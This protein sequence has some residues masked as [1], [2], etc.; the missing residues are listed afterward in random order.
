MGFNKQNDWVA[1]MMNVE[2]NDNIQLGSN[3]NLTLYSNGITPDNTGLKDR[4]YYKNI[5]QIQ[6]KFV[7]EN[8]QFNDTAF[9]Q[10]Y[11]SATKS[12]QEF[13]EIDFVERMLDEIGVSPYDSS[14]LAKPTRKVQ[15]ISA[16]ITPFHDKNRTTYGTANLWETGSATFSD[17]E[18]AQANFVRDENGNK[19]DWTPNDRSGF[20]SLF[21]PAIAYASYD[22]DVYDE[23]GRLIHRKGELKLDENG[24]PYTE[25]L[26]DRE[27]FGKDV[28]KWSDTFSVEGS[29][30]NK[31]DIF[32]SDGLDKSTWKIVGKTALMIAPYFTPLGAAWGWAN[33]VGG[34]LTAM[35]SLVKSL[36]GLFTGDSDNS[37]LAKSMNK[38]DNIMGR[39]KPTMSDSAKGRFWSLENLGDLVV[40]SSAQL[41]SQR[42]IANALA[43]WAPFKSKA[44]NDLL[45]RSVSTGYMAMTSATDTYS[46][47]KEAGASDRIAG[48]GTLLTMAGFYTLLSQGYFK[49]KL[50]EGS[51]L[52]EDQRL[53]HNI[54][55][56]S[57][58]VIKKNF[59]DKL[60][61]ATKDETAKGLARAWGWLKEALKDAPKGFAY[62]AKPFLSR[63]INEGVE[64]TMEEVLQDMVKGLT[65]GLEAIGV[66]C[67]ED[68]GKLDYNWDLKS[69]LGRYGTSFVGGALGGAVFEAYNLRELYANPN[70]KKLLG[71]TPI[72]RMYTDIAQGRAEDYRKA[73]I[74]RGEIKKNGNANLTASYETPDGPT[75]F[76]VYKSGTSSDNQNDA[77]TNEML[78]LVDVAESVYAK[79]NLIYSNEELLKTILETEAMK[80]HLKDKGMSATTFTE[81]GKALA[82]SGLTDYSDAEAIIDALFEAEVEVEGTKVKLAD[83]VAESVLHDVNELRNEIAEIELEIQSKINDYPELE[84][85]TDED[86]KRIIKSNS[87]IKKLEEK[88]DGLLKQF[89]EIISGKQADLYLAQTLMFLDNR[90]LSTYVGFGNDRDYNSVRNIQNFARFKHGIADYDGLTDSKLK[91]FIAD[92]Y[93]A[94]LS[95]RASLLRNVATMHIDLSEKLQ[96]QLQ[97]VENFLKDA[98]ESHKY[99][100][101]EQRLT[102]E[103]ALDALNSERSKVEKKLAELI[104]AGIDESDPKFKDV[105]LRIGAIKRNLAYFESLPKEMRFNDWFDYNLGSGQTAEA[106]YQKQEYIK[107]FYSDSVSKKAVYVKDDLLKAYLQNF[108]FN[109]VIENLIRKSASLANIHFDGKAIMDIYV[110]QSNDNRSNIQE[111]IEDLELELAKGT[112][113]IGDFAEKWNLGSEFLSE[114]IDSV[115]SI[116]DQNNPLFTELQT[117]INSVI[118][119][120]KTNPENVEK[121]LNDLYLFLNKTSPS[122]EP[123]IKWDRF[124]KN[125]SDDELK[126]VKDAESLAKYLFNPYGTNDILSFVEDTIEIMEGLPKS[127]IID[128]LQ[129]ISMQL[130]GQPSRIFELIREAKTDMSA[131]GYDQYLMSE[132]VR[133]EIYTAEGMINVLEGLLTGSMYGNINELLNTKR[134]NPF[135]ILSP[136]TVE[137][138][139]RE[140]GFVK[141]QFNALKKVSDINQGNKITEN[142]NITKIDSVK[143]FLSFVNPSQGSWIK[144]IEEKIA[145]KSWSNSNVIT[146]KPFHDFARRTDFIVTD[147]TSWSEQQF[148]EFYVIEAEFKENLYKWFSSLQEDEKAEVMR[149]IANCNANGLEIINMAE[150]EFSTDVDTPAGT[151]G[152][153]RYL[154]SNLTTSNAEFQSLLEKS[155]ED[156]SDFLPFYNQ[157]FC[158]R[159]AYSS[160]VAKDLYNIFLE[161]CL[162]K[163][164]SET[165]DDF[166]K[167]STAIKDFFFI[168]GAPG[169]GK[170]SAVTSL[171]IKVLKNKFGSDLKVIAMVQDETRKKDFSSVIGVDAEDT[172]VADEFIEQYVY[173]GIKNA[174]EKHQDGKKAGH[175]KTEVEDKNVKGIN[176]F[177][178]PAS[179]FLFVSDEAT[180]IN[181]AQII[182]ITKWLAKYNNGKNAWMLGLGDF[183]QSGAETDDYTDITDTY[184][185][186]SVRLTS[187]FRSENNGKA[188]NENLVRGV[189]K[190]GV[191]KWRNNRTEDVV[192]LSKTEVYPSFSKLQ[193]SLIGYYD[194]ETGFIYGDVQKQSSEIKTVIDKLLD[195]SEE[196]PSICIITDNPD[197]YNEY[198]SR[199][200]D[201]R[202]PKQA[203][204]GQWDYV[205][206]DVDFTFTPENAFFKTRSFYTIMTRAKKGTIW[207]GPVVNGFK[208]ESTPDAKREIAKDMKSS[209][210]RSEY[211]QW[212]KKLFNLIPKATV[213]T[214]TPGGQS[215]T[216]GQQGGQQGGSGGGQG[217]SPTT[218]QLAQ[219]I[220][221]LYSI[222][223]EEEIEEYISRFYE[224]DSSGSE[225]EEFRKKHRE[226]VEN[227]KTRSQLLRENKAVDYDAWDNW[228]KNDAHLKD[229]CPFE[230]VDLDTYRDYL[231]YASDVILECLA[232]GDRNIIEQL[233]DTLEARFNS[234]MFEDVN[235]LFVEN[236]KSKNG[237]FYLRKI[238]ETNGMPL[239][240]VYYTCQTAD[241]KLITIPIFATRSTPTGVSYHWS[242]V[243]TKFEVKPIQISSGGN[244]FVPLDRISKKVAVSDRIIIFKGVKDTSKLTESQAAFQKRNIG[245]AFIL[246]SKLTDTSINDKWNSY[247]SCKYNEDGEITSFVDENNNLYI[248][249][250]GVQRV[251]SESDFQSVMKL[252]IAGKDAI[253]R[254]NTDAYEQVIKDIQ[255]I[256]GYRVDLTSALRTENGGYNHNN[257]FSPS[258]V[259]YLLN[260]FIHNAVIDLN[261]DE[262]GL[263]TLSKLKNNNNVV[264]LQLTG[265]NKTVVLNI[266][267]MD[268]KLYVIKNPSDEDFSTKSPNLIEITDNVQLVNTQSNRII[269]SFVSMFSEAIV[270]AYGSDK[271]IQDV[272]GIT[273]SSDL[274][275]VTSAI[276]RVISDTTPSGNYINNFD[277]C[278]LY[279]DDYGN[280][281][282]KSWGLVDKLLDVVMNHELQDE[283]FKLATY[284]RHHIQF[285]IFATEFNEDNES[286]GI[287]DP[288]VLTGFG[289]DVVDI[290]PATYSIVF[291]G[292]GDPL[293][294]FDEKG[295]SGEIIKKSQAKYVKL[296]DSRF[297]L[298]PAIEVNKAWMD[299]NTEASPTSDTDVYNIT[300]IN[301]ATGEIQIEYEQNGKRELTIKL[302]NATDA[303]ALLDGL[304]EKTYKDGN[305]SISDDEV[306]YNNEK[307]TV[308][309]FRYIPEESA[310]AV[311][312]YNESGTP[313]QRIRPE[314]M[315]KLKSKSKL[316]GWN[317][318][319][320]YIFP[321]NGTWTGIAVNRDGFYRINDITNNASIDKITNVNESSN[322]VDGVEITNLSV[323]M[324]RYKLNTKKMIFTEIWE[325]NKSSM[326]SVNND[327]AKSVISEID[328]IIVSNLGVNDCISAINKILMDNA[329]KLGVLYKISEQGIQRGTDKK[330]FYGPKVYEMINSNLLINDIDI[331]NLP[332]IVVSLEDN[333]GDKFT[334]TYIFDKA[335]Q[336]ITESKFDPLKYKNFVSEL[337]KSED[338]LVVLDAMEIDV[339]EHLNS[340]DAAK[341]R[342][343]LG[344]I[345]SAFDDNDPVVIEIE[346]LITDINNNC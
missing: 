276:N 207:A 209:A 156:E 231:R 173:S 326:Q 68:A 115:T 219:E 50:F 195:T 309:G 215:G 270:K 286:W 101:N 245:K 137:I 317:L 57:E 243:A 227:Y 23:N 262:T 105:L 42:G 216:E 85:K 265:N 175:T 269:D 154:L 183:Y 306:Y 130:T 313:T 125:I 292:K 77:V 61:T 341:M 184:F 94:F 321:D 250:A 74:K 266:V 145:Q 37:G 110:E 11:E 257:V 103:S 6:N 10:F 55:Q 171:F 314:T 46:S 197:T 158:I 58:Y 157:E 221:Q 97:D 52:D 119:A 88:R 296:D 86:R 211:V 228:I 69:A 132:A 217:G 223:T 131:A 316:A 60:S 100:F 254:L 65:K 170:S 34:F 169:T 36:D 168:D 182:A 177:G 53:L 95:Q 178:S 16:T 153:I 75:G 126:K 261:K 1:V 247:L 238:G 271:D 301:I 222:P 260:L 256:T 235:R 251:C 340:S 244:K 146:F 318:D 104:N 79:H 129:Q 330:Y 191:S 59:G 346:E 239:N 128:L 315:E 33:A 304:P 343:L 339:N 7:D 336:S 81:K 135:T 22:E 303:I 344:A 90:L 35:P 323:I 190:N 327:L 333:N 111:I 47:L 194:S 141:D 91:E 287:A 220:D 311:V 127:P 200:I 39:F 48:A 32:D 139:K 161:T 187:S 232:S 281:S 201:V 140:F 204:G 298:S 4:D 51:L 293:N 242:N 214:P 165:N 2:N 202:K 76:R 121:A 92:D 80:E 30:F 84:R 29:T 151:W 162:E 290:L 325:R 83:I 64:E 285:N 263:Y 31:L 152:N 258:A 192:T 134:E 334:K 299:I 45:A 18:V 229:K 98:T 249:L 63:S 328:N 189:L 149:M 329:F 282:K 17:R 252:L 275:A 142:K 322:T 255:K 291:T 181:E 225:I 319:L 41:Y 198:I 12:Y 274:N 196:K 176:I 310:F 283:L 186:V 324:Q 267:R 240:I 25:L 208:F 147:V 264:E 206:T 62:E 268:D 40:S 19:L 294:L 284:F 102:I 193:K 280:V 3:P 338:V 49:E 87:Y 305:L 224:S 166:I 253:R 345:S 288:D 218:N 179:R 279:K 66:D 138:L 93:D 24:D 295:N 302:K 113:N 342:A 118:S 159:D 72:R 123:Y 89:Q 70:Y 237:N 213:T 108:D 99:L 331:S 117:H 277:L 185:G 210:A 312:L 278:W 241:Q 14:R 120:L 308:L 212:R 43:K 38:L 21:S 199:G 8:G 335:S 289:S 124:S 150:D 27:A 122:G 136:N 73:I 114:A 163:L 96:K 248:S 174:E 188:N 28:V 15:N 56:M 307:S 109:Y 144:E 71:A 67:T 172:Y 226:H 82:N 143:R 54:G 5:P 155:L 272:L 112:F 116:F 20:K 107:K 44:S 230:N 234:T 133:K 273:N 297:L 78:R 180:F 148:D 259:N 106:L 167:T 9:N 164:K 337:L 246:V 26:G 320:I 332:K 233:A 300:G 205:I 236:I 13:A 160:F 203:Q